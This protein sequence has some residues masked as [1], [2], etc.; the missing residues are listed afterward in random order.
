MKKIGFCAV[1]LT[2]SLMGFAQ[3]EA[4]KTT[5]AKKFPKAEKVT[6][7]QENESEWEAEFKLNGKKHGATF[8]ANGQWLET[9]Q[10]IKKSA[11]PEAIKATLNTQFK[12]YKIDDVEKVITQDGTFYEM[13][14]E[15]GEEEWEVM[16]DENGAI[17]KKESEKEEES[18]E[19]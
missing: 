4:V 3:N 16:F 17:V 8:N 19:D 14:L 12:G 10:A 13:E 1:A 15:K 7:E 18:N 11:L 6:W 5:F 9:E 2:F